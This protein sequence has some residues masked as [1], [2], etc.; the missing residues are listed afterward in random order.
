M[1]M[2]D[3]FK[4]GFIEFSGRCGGWRGLDDFSVFE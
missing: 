3:I 4:V 1:D 2:G